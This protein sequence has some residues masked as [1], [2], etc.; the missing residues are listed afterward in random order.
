MTATFC[1]RNG[2]RNFLKVNRPFS[3]LLPSHQPSSYSSFHQ[4]GVKVPLIVRLEG[5]NV[6]EGKRILSESDVNI[7]S[8]Q[9]LDDA[10]KK[11][12]ESLA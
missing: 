8:A 4:V 1:L 6:E 11:A 3:M 7:I 2:E 12:V 5:T 10:A 9:D